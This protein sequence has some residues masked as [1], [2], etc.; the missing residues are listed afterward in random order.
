MSGRA[1]TQHAEAIR[2]VLAAGPATAVALESRLGLSQP[3][4][5]RGIAALGDDAIRIGAARS[6]QY[7]LRDTV[8]GLA[9]MPVYRVDT[10][11]Q[12]R[13]LGLL[14]PARPEGFVFQEVAPPGGLR[15]RAA[16]YSEGLPWWLQD[17]RPQGFLGRA[18]AARHAAALG[19]PAS[20][21]EWGDTQMLQALLRHGHDAVG[22]LLLGEAARDAFVHTPQPAALKPTERAVAYARL[23]DEASRGE[24][25][26]SSAGGEQPKFM[27]YACD[28]DGMPRHVLVKF[29]VLGD[30][31]VAGRWRDLLLAEH[32]AL[33]TLGQAGLAA[34]RS[35][36]IDQGA[37]RFL[38]VERFDRVGP[39]GRRALFSLAALEAEFIG[40]A[41]AP[42]PVLTHR[43]ADAGYVTRAAADTAA[44]LYA[45]GTLIGN[46]DMH[47]G[48]LS[49][50]SDAG[51]P[52]DLAPAYDM[53]PMALAPRSGGALPVTLPPPALRASVPNATW[54]AAL[55][56]AQDWHARLAAETRLTAEWGPCQDALGRHLVLAT[57]QAQRLG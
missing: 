15:P 41:S 42:W 44:L 50:L 12:V 38:E 52:C 53:L 24:M 3:T 31:P 16:T 45:F 10:L 29:S 30:H 54:R 9:D 46:T 55:A 49:F 28:D 7:A 56:L 5:S 26:G 37:Q 4:V 1:A 32:L 34:A 35:A 19:L 23:S 47:H 51:P 25:P 20:L 6:I 17:M 57:V 27:A 14:R 48:N 8:R 11:G 33:Q 18:Y 39:L 22:N 43:L 2:R 13:P 36:V 40:D 21:N